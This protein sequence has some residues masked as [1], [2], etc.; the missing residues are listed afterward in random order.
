MD[1]DDILASVD[2][3]AGASPASTAIDHQLLTRFWVAERAVSEVLPWPTALME[4]MMDRVRLQIETIEDLAASSSDAPDPSSKSNNATLNLRLS[5][6]QTDLA[7]TQFLLRSVLRTRL[8][9]LSKHSMHYLV[10]LSSR[11]TKPSATQSQTQPSQSSIDSSG[12]TNTRPEDSVP[13]ISSVTDLSPL[14]EAEAQFLHTHQSLLASHYAGSFMGAF[15]RNL[16]RLDD[17]AGGTSMVQGPENREV[18]F[19]RC[20]SGEVPVVV[21]AAGEEDAIDIGVTMRMG[22]VWVVRWE[23]VR[24]AWERGEVELL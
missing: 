3:G 10:L 12:T 19:V 9:K 22:D 18:V 13:D 8:A 24:D 16:R 15:P 4:R 23:G 6:L 11:S 2:R 1:I 20:L 7:R 14:S 21:A 17:N 5:I